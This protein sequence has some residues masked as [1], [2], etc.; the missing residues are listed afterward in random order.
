[1]SNIIVVGCG[2]VGSRLALMLSN[3]EN[4]VCV[5]DRD[6]RAFAS[7]GRDFNGATFAGVGYDEDVLMKAG[8][9][10][11]DFLA[12]VTQSDNVNLMVVEIAR[13]LYDVP[14]A[15][16]R[17]YNTGHER[18]YLQLGIDYVCGTALVAEE[19][20]SKIS[21]GLGDHITTL[22]D[23]EVVQFAL[24]LSQTRSDYIKVS[25]LESRHKIRVC[26]FERADGEIS[27]IPTPSSVLY[28]GDT[29]LVALRHGMIPEIAK[30]MQN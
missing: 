23:C 5:I 27:S 4:N 24:D 20:F 22:G 2:R 9:D 21:S 6:P 12:A 16:A 25:D 10:E 7:L 30:Y 13:R 1:M 15:V 28:H 19:I 8:I 29:V 18:A 26:A 11:C 14:H 3:Y 17:L